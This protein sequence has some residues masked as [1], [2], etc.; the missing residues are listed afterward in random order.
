MKNY[1][2]ILSL[3]AVGCIVNASLILGCTGEATIKEGE[4]EKD[5]AVQFYKDIYPISKEIRDVG[6]DWNDFY[7]KASDNN[8][9]YD[10]IL[11]TIKKL[12]KRLLDLQID[13]SYAYAPEPLRD[14]KNS[15]A[16]SVSTGIE[17]FMIAEVGFEDNDIDKALQA[18]SK[19]LEFNRLMSQTADKWD[20]GLEY[21]NLKASEFIP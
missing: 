2:V 10:E 8:P 17:A 20:D 1:K 5:K 18:D 13:L 7:L 19:F 21:F 12:K 9:T 14:L 6:D 4:N 11:D 15:L 16:L 3:L